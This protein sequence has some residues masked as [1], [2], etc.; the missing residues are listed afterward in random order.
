M[1]A[2]SERNSKAAL[3]NTLTC[4][5]ENPAAKKPSDTDLTSLRKNTVTQAQLVDCWLST[6]EHKNDGVRVRLIQWK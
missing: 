2:K 1:S 5:Q 3:N 6:T 4:N